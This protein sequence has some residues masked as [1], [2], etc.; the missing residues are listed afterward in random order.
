MENY[1]KV[2]SILYVEDEKRI[3]EELAEVLENFC[4]HLYVADD[5]FQGLV[6][7]K[8]Y[9][10]SIVVT[11][12]KMPTMDGVEMS[13]KIREIN[14][15]A[16]IVFTTAFSDVD[17]FQEAI[18]LQVDGYILKPISL[19][20]LET[21]I[22]KICEDIRLRDEL[23][24]K[25]QMLLHASKLASI[26]E[27]I[28]NVAHQW[29][30]PL[31]VISLGINSIRADVE[32]EQL[33]KADILTY[34][35]TVAK[36]VEYLGK[37]INDFRSFFIPYNPAKTY[38]LQEFLDKCIDLVRTSLDSDTIETIKDVDK[39][40]NA[41]GDPNQL[42]QAVINIL[43]NARDA[44]RE[45]ENLRKKMIFI[46]TAKEDDEKNL[47]IVIKDNA[48]GIPDNIIDRV[49]EPYFTTKENL[50]GTGLGLYITHT[51]IE[52]NLK[53][54]VTVDNEVFIYEGEEYKGAR[55]VITLPLEEV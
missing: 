46:V 49:F 45:A 2:K 48:G 52:K 4:E 16:R 44:F 8:K 31:S 38:N 26:G 36:Q 1:S 32:L 41:F 28:G 12:I 18:E 5:G 40:I 50:G 9:N 37:T 27:M 24:E 22:L 10:P 54:T 55:F 39:N 33:D 53:G 7:F 43:N 20:S 3:R 51:I 17:F 23:V 42:I 35:D 15:E 6:Q 19:N 47:V 25:E 13:K 14:T 34:T 11:D 21:K 30:Q 29:R